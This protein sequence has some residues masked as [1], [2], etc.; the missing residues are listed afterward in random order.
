[1]AG[2]IGVALV[3]AGYWGRRLARVLAADDGCELRVVCDLDPER[4]NDVARAHGCVAVTSSDTAMRDGDV[5]A[6]VVA[7]PSSSHGALVEGALDL[8]RHVLVEKPLAESPAEV[9]R[10]AA[11]TRAH[12]L[13]V[14]C[15]QTYRF[16][17]VTA[18]VRD[19]VAAEAFG[20]L[21]SVESI[22]TNQGH[23]Q[24]DVDVF[25]DLAYHDLAIFDAVVPAGLR[26]R[27]EVRATAHDLAGVGR[28]HHGQLTLTSPDGPRA[29]ITVDWHAETKVRTM[30]FASAEHTVTWD[31]VDG[32]RVQH[33]RR[34]V[35][36]GCGEPLA[37]VV[38]EFL[39]AIRARR[40]A[41]CGPAQE[42]PVL[43]VLG[44]ATDSAARDGAP[45]VVDLAGVQQEVA[46]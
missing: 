13:V 6:V 17:P 46:R 19:V 37:A 18:S 36:V 43:T 16:A 41:S 25:W 32:P 39:D 45:V 38:S 10:L 28:P 1:M 42:L 11:R 12:E 15:D 23:S 29:S 26:G 34:P 24:P 31:D 33:D 44:A 3:G 7:T 5:H 9:R 4:A 20:A 14:M 40:P 30:R 27:Y 2:T 8:G 21:Q 35:A 22:R